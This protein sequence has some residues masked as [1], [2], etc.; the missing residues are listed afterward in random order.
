M[1][2]SRLR[3]PPARNW[4]DPACALVRGLFGA[5]GKDVQCRQ[6]RRRER[7]AQDFRQRGRNAS[8]VYI[9]D[10]GALANFRSRNQEKSLQFRMSG[11]ISMRSP[12]ADFRAPA[13]L[14]ALN[15]VNS[16]DAYLPRTPRQARRPLGNLGA[17]QYASNAVS[18]SAARRSS[19]CLTVAAVA[20]S[21]GFL[22][23]T[24]ANRRLAMALLSSQ[25]HLLKQGS[26]R[27]L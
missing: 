17:I 9:A 5:T 3:N 21:L 22:R 2:P 1:R 24:A 25:Q 19:N 8:H 12:R 7:D 26:F 20:W 27:D 13:A 15:Q 4:R 18:G 14:R 10:I 23:T 11:R 16:R 6:R